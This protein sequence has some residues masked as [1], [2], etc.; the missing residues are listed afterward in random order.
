LIRFKLKSSRYNL[1]SHDPFG[2]CLLMSLEPNASLLDSDE[3]KDLYRL[4]EEA[5]ENADGGISNLEQIEDASVSSTY[6]VLSNHYLNSI[7]RNNVWHW[8]NK[9]NIKGIWEF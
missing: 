6:P 4:V 9:R 1:T 3:Y 2:P 7:S 8:L 5:N